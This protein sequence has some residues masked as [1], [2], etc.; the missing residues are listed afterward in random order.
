MSRN[1]AIAII[2]FVIAALAII[3]AYYLSK[4]QIALIPEPSPV[5]S[6]LEGFP[7]IQPSPPSTQPESGTDTL[8]TVSTPLIIIEPYDQTE[9]SSPVKISGFL[10][11]TDSRTTL[12]IKDVNGK[13][14]GTSSVEGCQEQNGCFFETEI[15]FEKPQT[16]IGSVEAL[17]SSTKASLETISVKFK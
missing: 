4:R 12:N 7:T 13:I 6:P 1:L 11:V 14:L 5:S 3:G 2:I 9:I 8:D 17:N 15:T 10:N 16:P